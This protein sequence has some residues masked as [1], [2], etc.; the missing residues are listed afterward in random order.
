MYT[1]IVLFVAGVWGSDVEIF[2]AAILLDTSI[3][4]FSTQTNTWQFFSKNGIQAEPQEKEKC[5]YLYNIS[6]IHFEV[7]T[8]VNP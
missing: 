6:H 3:Y 4:V 1:F 2:A 7:V 8:D 5:I